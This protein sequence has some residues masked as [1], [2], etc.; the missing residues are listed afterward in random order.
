M[1]FPKWLRYL[2]RHLLIIIPLL[3]GWGAVVHYAGDQLVS[4]RIQ[5]LLASQNSLLNSQADALRY[6]L[7]QSLAFLHALP[8][9]FA[10]DA[11]LITAVRNHGAISTAPKEKPALFLTKPELV[12][13]SEA[14]KREGE[15]FGLDLVLLLNAV[16]DCIA[17]S[18][19]D[20]KENGTGV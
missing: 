5:S 13:L 1:Q 16:G 10:L 8:I 20:T 15:Q 17:T 2:A 19:I 18:N 4:R 7:H 11:D 12:A 6:N 9:H 14:L 3:V